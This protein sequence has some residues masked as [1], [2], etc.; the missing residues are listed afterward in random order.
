MILQSVKEFLKP[1]LLKFKIFRIYQSLKRSY[2]KKTGLR[3]YVKRYKR[4]LNEVG[5]KG[6]KKRIVVVGHM[7]TE[8]KHSLYDI[9]SRIEE[10]A[11]GK[12]EFVTLDEIA[13]NADHLWEKKFK[14]VR[15]PA[16]IY[17]DIHENTISLD[18][19]TVYENN[20]Y[21]QNAVAYWMKKGFDEYSAKY[22]AALY[23]YAYEQMI[24]ILQPDQVLIWNQFMASHMICDHVCKANGI[25]VEYIEYGVL[26]GTYACE[27]LGQMGASYP[28]RE[29]EAFINLPVT[30][31]QLQH[32]DRVW[33]FLKASGLN[34]NKQ[35]DDNV[36]SRIQSRMMKDRPIIIFAGN[37][38][39]DSGIVPY[40]EEAKAFHSPFFESSFDAMLYLAQLAERNQWNLIFKPHPLDI[41]RI[42]VSRIPEHVIY[43][44]S[45][46]LNDLIDY[47]DVVVTI[48]SQTAYVSCIR[49]TATVMLGY[50]QLRNKGCIYQPETKA[51][52]EN[53][54]SKAIE[55]GYTESQRTAFRKHIAQMC[56]YYLFDDNTDRELRYGQ[57]VEAFGHYLLKE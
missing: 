36:V 19:E 6:T 3:R 41:E 22:Y 40:T 50:N 12:V 20:G 17:F 47:A 7:Y 18:C 24:Q 38:D 45:G 42:D 5:S 52:I 23:K 30:E 8:K 2:Y 1:F 28:A 9:F 48:M 31:E 57:S 39:T 27:N 10:E 44:A 32:A 4:L 15:L 16:F 51:D 21:I 26:P 33:A 55:C 43:V 35:N 11:E 53:E 14:R 46:N 25:P 29:S 37:Y 49:E 56:T 13:N 34:R 54:L